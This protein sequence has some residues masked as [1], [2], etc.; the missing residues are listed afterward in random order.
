MAST[1]DAKTSQPDS[2]LLPTNA[3]LLPPL[4]RQ[5]PPPSCLREVAF[6]CANEVRGRLLWSAS[7]KREADGEADVMTDR[8]HPL[9]TAPMTL[10]T[11]YGLSWR[12]WFFLMQHLPLIARIRTTQWGCL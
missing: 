11:R 4:P 12:C 5:G 3:M 10:L 7:D 9:C 6:A 8:E 1:F 2:L